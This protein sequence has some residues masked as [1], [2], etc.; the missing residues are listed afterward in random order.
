MKNENKRDNVQK[1]LLEKYQEIR[2]SLLEDN[3]N[4]VNDDKMEK[5]TNPLFLDIPKTYFDAK[6]KIMIFGQETNGWGDGNLNQNTV[7]RL[8]EQYCKFHQNSVSFF[9]N[10]N[11]YN[12]IFFRA[13]RKISSLLDKKFG[14]G[15]SEVIW[16][17]IVKIGKHKGKGLPDKEIMEWQEPL[18]E[19]IRFE[20][21]LLKPDVVIFFTGPDYEQ[22][23]KKAFGDISYEPIQDYAQQKLTFIKST[24]LPVNSIRTYHPGYLNRIKDNKYIEAIVES[25]K[26]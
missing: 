3:K 5:M 1:I 23:I 15:N 6:F 25:I 20:V 7:E 17:N 26:L 24:H 12:V 8:M 9:Q 14:N 19:L 21:E 11:K 13:F 4:K 10:S 18:Y 2:K 22:Y 16:N